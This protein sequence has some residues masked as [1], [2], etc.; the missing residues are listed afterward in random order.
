MSRYSQRLSYSPT[1]RSRLAAARHRRPGN[2]RGGFTL[3]ELMV[4]IAIIVVLASITLPAV[5]AA[6]ETARK[7]QCTNNLKQYGIA[8]SN[9]H[10]SYNYLPVSI[11]PP[12]LTALPRIG[13]ATFLLPFFEQ[14][15]VYAIYNQQF[16]W[17]DTVNLPA[18][19]TRIGT[20]QCPSTPNPSRLDGNPQIPTAGTWTGIVAS[21]DYGATLGVDA[22]L[23]TLGYATQSGAGALLTN[24]TENV[25]SNPNFADITDGI[26]NTIFFAESAG[27]PFVYRRGNKLVNTDLTQSRVNGGGW[28]RPA[29][30]FT[31][32]GASFDG[33]TLPGQYVINATNGFDF[34]PN[35]PNAGAFPDPTYGTLGTGEAFSFHD[36]G[37]NV[38]FGDGSVKFISENVAT[39]VFASLVTRAGQEV[40]ST[41]SY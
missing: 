22:G 19:Q 17:F 36:G 21:T 34:G 24:L 37:V 38:V 13:V 2:D 16:N 32:H 14:E 25:T 15:N 27:R 35:G 3:I 26:S 9:F 39:N 5:Q 7:S 4:V 33:T 31:I 8:V 10:N 1:R 18:T 29:S 12:G 20:F 28:S 6:R 11:R 41:G 30:D 23:V 40:V